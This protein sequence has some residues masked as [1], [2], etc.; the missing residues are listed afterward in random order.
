MWPY[1]YDS[2]DSGTFPNQTSKNGTPAAVATGA[3]GGGPL[4][5]LPGQKLSACT[6]PGSDHPGPSVTDGRGVPE[7]DILEA[8]VD[9]SSFTGQ[10]SQSTQTAPFDYLYDFNNVSGAATIYN[11]TITYINSYKGGVYQQ[12][13]SAVTYTDSADYND[14]SYAPYGFELWSDPSNRQEGYITWYSNSVETWTITAAAIGP[15]VISGVQQRLI[16]E[17]PM[18]IYKCSVVS[19]E[20]NLSSIVHYFQPGALTSVDFNLS[21]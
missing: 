11:P 7:V 1:S 10:V 20:L 5:Y 21:L 13:M 17:E 18:V 8:Q 6:C 19:V 2:C 16:P 15:D 9:I 14:Q 4:S 3:P 12:A